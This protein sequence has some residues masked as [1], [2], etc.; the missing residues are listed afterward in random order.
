M[1]RTVWSEQAINSAK[2]EYL[3]PLV[4]ALCSERPPCTGQLFEAASGWVAAL[5]W[6]RSRGVTF[7]RGNETPSVEQVA[8][9][10]STSLT[11][12]CRRRSDFFCR[13]S[14]KSVISIMVRRTIQVAQNRTL[15]ICWLLSVFHTRICDLNCRN[16]QLSC[17]AVYLATLSEY[18][19]YL[20]D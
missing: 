12:L 10:S 17:A 4:V 1:T 9:V 15:S 3:A 8:E 6:Q 13:L 16:Y 2:A 18:K 14:L 11:R 7:G 20:E 5:R 19:V